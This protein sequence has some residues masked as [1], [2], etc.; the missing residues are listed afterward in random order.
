MRL[1]PKQ[2]KE[3]KRRKSNNRH[4]RLFGIKANHPPF[5][6]GVG[7]GA[8]R[9]TK[10]WLFCTLAQEQVDKHRHIEDCHIVIAIHISGLSV[11]RRWSTAQDV[12]DHGC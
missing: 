1:N 4:D 7:D 3:E 6:I 5:L 12:V 11:E 8:L 10:N 2:G 9:V